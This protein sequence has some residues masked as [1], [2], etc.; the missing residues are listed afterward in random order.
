MVGRIS[1]LLA[2][3]ISSSFGQVFGQVSVTLRTNKSQYLAGEPIFVV[4]EVKNSGTEAVGYSYCDGHID[5]SVEHTEK[6]RRPNLW[7]CS[8]GGLGGMG[9]GID[10]PPMLAPGRSTS[11]QYLLKDYRLSPGAYTLHARGK[12]GVRWKSYSDYRTSAAPPPPPKHQ[13]GD[14]VPD[15]TFDVSSPIVL[16]SAS[17]EE[18]E[19]AY[20]PYISDAEGFRTG[21]EEMR[22]AREAIAEMAPEFLEKTIAG[23]ATAPIRTP[24]LAVMGLRQIETPASRADLVMLY[25]NS[26]D[27]NLR[28]QIVQALAELGSHEQLILCRLTAW[29][30][31]AL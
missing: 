1:L 12:A 6:K 10:H 15:A 5:L 14:P 4:V 25:D 23:F 24:E 8:A 3:L 2:T 19:R 22:R 26:S 28:S 7:G 18:L 20:A 31:H 11:F 21:T 9:C 29:T 16:T 13:E 27:L 30:G 17:Q